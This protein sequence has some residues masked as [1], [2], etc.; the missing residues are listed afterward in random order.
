MVMNTV[1]SKHQYHG[2]ASLVDMYYTWIQREALKKDFCIQR[3]DLRQIGLRVNDGNVDAFR[4]SQVLWH[5]SPL[6][7]E[8]MFSEAMVQL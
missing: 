8:V 4:F 6:I 3:V 5:R 7:T 1:P 2:H